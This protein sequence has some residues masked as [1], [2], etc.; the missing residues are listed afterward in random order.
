MCKTVGSS[1]ALTP[2][3]RT[4]MNV[5][6]DWIS[7]PSLLL[8]QVR[9]RRHHPR[10]PGRLRRAHHPRF[11]FPLQDPPRP[12]TTGTARDIASRMTTRVREHAGRVRPQDLYLSGSEPDPHPGARLCQGRLALPRAFLDR[13]RARWS[14]VRPPAA[15]AARSRLLFLR[16]P[17]LRPV[18]HRSGRAY[19]SPLRGSQHHHPQ[20]QHY[21]D[22]LRTRYADHSI[23]TTRNSTSSNSTMMTR[24]GR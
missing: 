24:C 14:H 13:D 7:S 5:R 23:I 12:A 21:D 22:P 6:E 19:Q 10:R 20:Q 3:R 1:L 16:Q 2:A 17:V 11:R 9:R 4:R 18:A 15:T 8:P